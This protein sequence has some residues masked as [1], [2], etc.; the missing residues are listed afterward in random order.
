METVIIHSENKSD[1]NLLLSLAKKLGMSTKTLSKSEV[2]DWELS[3]KIEAGMNSPEVS[4]ASVLKAL[5]K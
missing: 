4:R 3:R 1:L 2:E 5:G